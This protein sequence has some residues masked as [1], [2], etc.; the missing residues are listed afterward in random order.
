MLLGFSKAVQCSK[1]ETPHSRTPPPCKP[2]SLYAGIF[3]A[4]LETPLH[5]IHGGAEDHGPNDRSS[6]AHGPNTSR[7]RLRAGYR[8][9]GDLGLYGS[10][11]GSHL[12]GDAARGA[13][14]FG[15]GLAG[16]G[17]SNAGQAGEP[18]GAGAFDRGEVGGEL[19]VNGVESSGSS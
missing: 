15:L 10:G 16:G 6:S 1:E 17:G 2:P 12:A 7:R 18:A 19:R 8:G 3:N 14:G 5:G 4:P 13:L 11:S 9:R